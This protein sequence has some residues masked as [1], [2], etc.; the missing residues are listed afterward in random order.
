MEI[1]N[2]TQDESDG[3]WIFFVKEKN[4][5]YSFF[6]SHSENLDDAYYSR[7]I[8]IYKIDGTPCDYDVINEDLYRR[9]QNHD[10]LLAVINYG[11]KLSI[12]G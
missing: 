5:E 12:T 6:C 3:K 11:N 1:L 10:E 4:G 7:Q 2:K 8:G 9:P